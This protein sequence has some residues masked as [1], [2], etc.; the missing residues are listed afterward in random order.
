M[1]YFRPKTTVLVVNPE[2]SDP[3]RQ[4]TVTLRALT[5]HER[6][7]VKVAGVK[8]TISGK[9]S[10]VQR[11]GDADMRV[12]YDMAAGT[13]MLLKLCVV[14]WHGPD[15]DEPCTDENKLQ[16]PPEITERILAAIDDLVS[17]IAED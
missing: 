12:D 3:G 5:Y 14:D 6:Q 2:E 1:G 10:E 4:N 15:F 7:R 16:L 11:S 13:E 17:P 8:Q 9:L